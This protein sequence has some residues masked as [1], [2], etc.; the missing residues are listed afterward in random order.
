MRRLSTFAP[1]LL[2]LC[3]LMTVSSLAQAQGP[4]NAVGILGQPDYTANQA[5]CG[6]GVSD[7]CFS[8]IDS[9]AIDTVN[10]RLFVADSPPNNR[11]LVF[12]LDSN[13]NVSA[14]AA[15]YVLG[16]CSFTT[17][18]TGGATQ[19]TFG[20]DEFI[21]NLAYDSV[22]GRLFVSDSGHNRVLAFD[23]TPADIANCEDA[24]FVLGQTDFTN[25]GGGA[26]QWRLHTPDDMDYDAADELLFVS[27]EDN[28]R[29][30]AFS[31]P[32]GLTSS[33][34]GENALFVLGQPS[35][36][37]H[38]AIGTGSYQSGLSD[39][40]GLA[41]DS[42][43]RRIF[44]SDYGNNRVMVFSIPSNP[45]SAINGENASYVLG[46]P[47]FAVTTESTSESG[48]SS[49]DDNNYDATSNRF[50]V[51]DLGNSRVMCFDGTPA[52]IA[53]GE[54][55]TSVLD[56]NRWTAAVSGVTKN[57]LGEPEWPHTFDPVNNHV[58]IYENTTSHRVLQFSFVHI[59]TTS[60]PAFTVGSPYS[61]SIGITQQQGSS[62]TYSVISGSLPTGLSLNS[63][64]GAI[65]GT[66]SDGVAQTFTVEVD[67]NFPAGVFFDRA[68]YTLSALG[69]PTPT[70]TRTPTPPPTPTPTP[71]PTPAPSP[72]V[73]LLPSPLEFGTVK[74]GQSSGSQTV[75]L[76]NGAAKKL[77]ISGTAIGVDFRVVSTTCSS[78]LN[79]GQSCDY[80]VSFQPLR[81]GTKS[82]VFKV[83]DSAHNS[84]QKVKL[85][86]VGQR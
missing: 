24:L 59:T 80:M 19:S 63:S 15:S 23:V 54:N 48:L 76:T 21:V 37:A 30:M 64:T 34:N 20:R 22:N 18:G 83:T 27:D 66:N 47:S 38:F 85:H 41:W 45:T 1:A 68:V 33:I 43:N 79:A 40:A 12:D 53:N 49:P 78:A 75:T 39:P 51:S 25:S 67:D 56:Q 2:A 61:Q 65:T 28:N 81:A 52:N 4:M 32:A 36:T 8:D 11:I 55:A 60:L 29:I 71:T 86:G 17:E 57:E 13:N 14:T 82:E 42:A 62:Q 46:Q 31:V 58:F 72:L 6:D 9:I 26:S 35:F 50:C 16:S 44:S 77:A 5:N 73:T 3:L 7:S 10:H 69:A 84:P 74:V 70:P